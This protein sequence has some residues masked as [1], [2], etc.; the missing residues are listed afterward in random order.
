[1]SC[2]PDGMLQNEE[3]SAVEPS[4]LAMAHHMTGVLVAH[5]YA[6]LPAQNINFDNAVHAVSQTLKVSITV[7]NNC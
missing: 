5:K 7:S 2:S 6:A 1:M 3:C 4:L